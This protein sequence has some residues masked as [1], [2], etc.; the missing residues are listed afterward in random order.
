VPA[1]AP[2][3][4]AAGDR[5]GDAGLRPGA[6]AG[7]PALPR[8]GGRPR[9]RGGALAGGE[10]RG[11]GRPARRDRPRHGAGR[12][13]ARPRR[14][15]TAGVERA[16]EPLRTVASAWGLH[17]C[18]HVPWD[19][20][21]RARPDLLSFDLALDPVGEEGTAVLRD[22]VGSG[23]WIAWGAIRVG[24]TERAADAARRVAEALAEVDLD[25]ARSLLTA[26]CGSGR[27]APARERQIAADLVVAAGIAMR[28]PRR[29][30]SAP[31]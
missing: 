17:L 8:A 14:L 30:T 24:S 25:P 26:S 6:R 22:L 5:P 20:V 9:R 16:W 7:Q 21:E 28:L 3:G 29:A 2:A 18:C 12:R 10:R 13:R 4:E 27:I 19:V 23:G 31:R 15:G 1:A 11:P